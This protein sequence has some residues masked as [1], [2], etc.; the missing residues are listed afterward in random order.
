LMKKHCGG[1]PNATPSTRNED[2]FSV[3]RLFAPLF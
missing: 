3:Q 1:L 2:P